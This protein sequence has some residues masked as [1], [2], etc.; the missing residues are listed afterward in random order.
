MM[1]SIKLL[2]KGICD[3][4]TIQILQYK[5]NQTLETRIQWQ[6]CRAATEM[7]TM[8]RAVRL[9]RKKSC[10]YFLSDVLTDP[11]NNYK[12]ERLMSDFQSILSLSQQGDNQILYIKVCNIK[13]LEA[14]NS[15]LLKCVANVTAIPCNNKN[16]YYIKGETTYKV[17]REVLINALGLTIVVTQ[18]VYKYSKNATSLFSLLFLSLVFFSFMILSQLFQDGSSDGCISHSIWPRPCSTCNSKDVKQDYVYTLHIATCYLLHVGGSLLPLAEVHSF[19]LWD[20]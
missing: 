6:F 2:Q 12:S 18:A 9:F 17:Q 11:T 3:L 16:K 8:K 15:F 1:Y 5:Y 20:E 13:K 4:Q 14:K 7:S 19:S 10:F